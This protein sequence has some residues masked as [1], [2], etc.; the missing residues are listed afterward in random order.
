MRLNESVSN[1]MLIG[2]MQLLKVEDTPEHRRDFNEQLIS[3][4]FIS[5]IYIDPAPKAGPNGVK[6]IEPGSKVQLPMLTGSDGKR[7]FVLYTDDMSLKNAKDS[8]GVGTP[9]VFSEN[10]AKLEIGE[11]GYMMMQQG[12]D[13]E[14]YPCEGVIINP[15][16]DNMIVKKDM[17]ITIFKSKMGVAN[18]RAFINAVKAFPGKEKKSDSVEASIDAE[19]A[20]D[21][22]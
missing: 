6:V 19:V 15:F 8:N 1:P 3:A 22:E 21:N 14:E 5:P 12:P 16:T 17:V 7:Y 9:D 20:D 11:L 2:A 4:Y 18:S 13:G 10:F